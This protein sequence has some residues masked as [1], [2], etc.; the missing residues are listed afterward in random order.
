MNACILISGAQ[1]PK[2]I[3]II[4]NSF[5]KPDGTVY[6]FNRGN[7][8]DSIPYNGVFPGEVLVNIKRGLDKIAAQPWSELREITAQAITDYLTEIDFGT[9][10]FFEEAST[11]LVPSEVGQT[12][13]NYVS[14]F[15]I[16]RLNDIG[17]QQIKVE[18]TEPDV[19]GNKVEEV[20]KVV[21]SV[22]E[23]LY[24]IFANSTDM[25]LFRT[26]TR[27]SII[28]ELFVGTYGLIADNSDLS[29]E[30]NDHQQR[31]IDNLVSTA[32]DILGQTKYSEAI[33]KKTNLT[34]KQLLEEFRLI[35]VNDGE[36]FR[37][38]LFKKLIDFYDIYFSENLAENGGMFY[39]A[40]AEERQRFFDYLLLKNFDTFIASYMDDLI[41]IQPGFENS[42]DPT[43]NGEP[44]Y[45]S[46]IQLN[47]E[48]NW[49]DS[50]IESISEHTNKAVQ[51]FLQTIE[52]SE[53]IPL[54]PTNFSRAV[55]WIRS[56]YRQ[57]YR[58]VR[59]NPQKLRD[60]FEKAY[61]ATKGNKRLDISI[62]DAIQVIYLEVFDNSPD[63]QSLYNLYRD[64]KY[65]KY[66]LYDMLL[67]Q[68]NKTAPL[69]Y[70]QTAYNSDE[71]T[72]EV[73]LLD[74]DAVAEKKTLFERSIMTYSQ[75]HNLN[76]L[77]S[78]Y[79][80]NFK[81]TLPDSTTVIANDE[82]GKVW[83]I[84][85]K[86]GSLNLDAIFGDKQISYF[87]STDLNRTPQELEAKDVV[88]KLL[89]NRAAREFIG[90][91]FARKFDSN[92][93]DILMQN[94]ERDI[95]GVMDL[96]INTLMNTYL[97]NTKVGKLID[98]NAD[99]NQIKQA[100]VDSIDGVSLDLSKSSRWFNNELRSLKPGGLF[101]GLGGL[102]TIAR[103]NAAITGDNAKSQIKDVNGNSLPKFGLSSAM[104][105]D[106][107]VIQN[108]SKAM[109][110]QDTDKSPIRNNLF[111]NTNILGESYVD[112]EV[113]NKEG[114]S[115]SVA[116]MTSAELAYH[117]LVN[118][119]LNNRKRSIFVQP[120]VYADKS[121]IWVKKID[122]LATFKFS[123][124]ELAKYNGL[125]LS[126][127][128]TEQAADVH[129]QTMNLAYESYSNVIRSDYAKLFALV[130][131]GGSLVTYTTAL[132][133]YNTYSFDQCLKH[134]N[135]LNLNT[136]DLHNYLTLAQTLGIEINIAPELHYQPKLVTNSDGRKVLRA[137]NNMFRFYKE[138]FANKELFDKKMYI[139]KGLYAFKF[140]DD[141]VKLEVVDSS[142]AIN[143]TLEKI[144]KTPQYAEW[145]NQDTREIIPFKVY[146]AEGKEL[147]GHKLS[148]D[149]VYNPEK[150]KIVLNPLID[151]Y[152]AIDNLVADNYNAILFGFN[153]G[154]KGQKDFEFDPNKVDWSDIRKYK[155][156][157]S[158]RTTA[159]YKRGVIGGATI[160]TLL[161]NKL[162]GVPSK[163]KIAVIQDIAAYTLNTQG[164][165]NEATPHDGGIFMNP[166]IGKL[167]MNSLP[168]VSLSII[169]RK[170]IAY[171]DMSEYG[172][173]GLLKCATFS[174]NNDYI[175]NA[176]GRI[177]GRRLLRKMT[178][179][180]WNDPRIDL[181]NQDFQG[182]YFRGPDFNYYAI[183][184]FSKVGENTYNIDLEQVD[185]SGEYT[186]VDRTMEN[187]TINSNYDLW[188][189]LG[190]ED[191]MSIS[192]ATNQLVFG[193]SSIDK[194]V[195]V[196]N[197]VAFI[198]EGYDP[199]QVEHTQEYFDQPMKNAQIA[200]LVNSSAIKNG[201]TNVN[202][203]DMFYKDFDPATFS[204]NM[205]VNDLTYFNMDI[206]FL[207]IQMNAEHEVDRAH[208]SEMTQ[209]ISSMEQSGLTHELAQSIYENI[210]EA[211]AQNL[212]KYQGDII[213]DPKAKSKV[214]RLL[215]KQLVR[216]F[217]NNTEDDEYGLAQ[218]YIDYIKDD[219]LSNKDFDEQ[220]LKIPFNDP[221]ISG[222]FQ[223][224]F[225]NGINKDII[226]RQFPGIAAVMAPSH[227]IIT[228]YDTPN[229]VKK[230][231]DL[232]ASSREEFE[233]TM[234]QLDRPAEL[235][236]ILDVGQ[237]RLGDYI[238]I[239]YPDGN[240]EEGWVERY[241]K[242]PMTLRKVLDL[243]GVE[244]V[245]ISIIGS[246]GR[247]L[248]AQN[249]A[250][251]INGQTWTLFDLDSSRLSYELRGLLDLAKGQEDWQS[252]INTAN[253]SM[254]TV[255]QEE[256]AWLDSRYNNTNFEEAIV[257]YITNK[258]GK[259]DDGLYDTISAYITQCVQR[260]LNM[261]QDKGLFH[262][263]VKFRTGE[264]YVPAGN[265]K[266]SA[267]EMMLGKVWAQQFM[268]NEGDKLSDINSP[269]FFANKLSNTLETHLNSDYYDMY[270]TRSN[271]KHLHVV[272]DKSVVENLTPVQVPLAR[273][274]DGDLFRI[275]N[276]E[277][278]YKVSTG[279]K[280]Y[281]QVDDN[282]ESHEIVY[283]PS[284]ELSKAMTSFE[285]SKLFT[286]I[287][288]NPTVKNIRRL[289]KAVS[290]TKLVTQDV[291]TQLEETISS[292]G[293]DRDVNLDIVYQLNNALQISKTQTLQ[294]LSQQ[295]YTSFKQAINFI[296]ARIP[297]QSMQSF[298]NMTIAG[299]VDSKTNVVYVPIDQLIYQGSDY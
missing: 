85:M 94:D 80:I 222:I 235:D 228:V 253:P 224:G 169:H 184:N 237:V 125:S 290:K 173:S 246:K 21:P 219:L 268:L 250:F 109:L 212:F 52:V 15:L 115:K 48:Q 65:M 178:D 102:L 292:L 116:K 251:V 132:N 221:N 51:L 119:F 187:V 78:K 97:Y 89:N 56:T 61:K 43:I 93:W 295:M 55:N 297:A 258:N 139:E 159:E 176:H 133:K 284:Q 42:F 174:F 164:G 105:D 275:E 281:T 18:K 41:T 86:L 299:F 149:D 282:G 255:L 75:K 155:E 140:Q 218:T 248:R 25:M 160:H 168:E 216:T 68:V 209:V 161:K 92:Y 266:Y 121:R 240:V 236:G 293:K 206:D 76:D 26:K 130:E 189:A 272:F 36:D 210:G 200:Y 101:N 177:N 67:N 29:M 298:M 32:E 122:M 110:Y 182:M 166:F 95:A 167:E 287:Q 10:D 227:D 23:G 72:Y 264:V 138:M 277:P 196:M 20:V 38:D 88:A 137:G 267:N 141:G 241:N 53:N 179:I 45:S 44:K 117:S 296:V 103:T 158:A 49:D 262:M 294:K 135:N 239:S 27:N 286:S 215:G 104:N 5:V 194:V 261:L 7:T 112:L 11:N 271:G 6:S 180:K 144:S 242:G 217:A 279:F 91:I 225:T 82:N 202:P 100:V 120:T 191:S 204:G 12:I 123:D 229:G 58:Q 73:K 231:S 14:K 273:D 143:P 134:F 106:D 226:K 234:A 195:E 63:S 278:T 107:F 124:P 260:D 285:A 16:P 211:I 81:T 108:L 263:P 90:D 289:S 270:L 37:Y 175:R 31:L 269:L 79:D 24:N 50:K 163:Y 8:E 148:I 207:G 197:N 150:F 131:S 190:G 142:G 165:E 249:A 170:P 208:V 172:V 74:S 283:I 30:M 256:I 192:N 156:E 247:N 22:S 199:G 230:Y 183:S 186:G 157:E 162:N 87:I 114:V 96:A 193:E 153:Y 28:R 69:R 46:N 181:S 35:D 3:E 47:P 245:N 62:R 1:D 259:K 59:N 244:G 188:E 152:F 254:F 83:A 57:E 113:V 146:D 203:A 111:Y 223:T 214:Y 129:R 198:K 213:N 19:S 185:K 60:L 70:L 127:L 291:K 126:K 238:R 99:V 151:R 128:T 220:V 39:S 2:L 34:D 118:R 288:I 40:D 274:S 276:N 13:G 136:F 171:F 201:A 77:V 64:N 280:F 147:V 154:H 232:Q 66:N 33:N 98:A 205:S 71:E 84:G 4:A 54:N 257:K 265:I 145:Y 252:V 17:V 9:S 233:N 243:R